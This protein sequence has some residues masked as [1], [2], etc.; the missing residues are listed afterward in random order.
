MLV[1]FKRLPDT[2]L[3]LPRC[4]DQL[5]D[6]SPNQHTLLGLVGKNGLAVHHHVQYTPPGRAYLGR[7]IQLL[8]NFPLEA[9]GLQ[10]NVDSG[11]TALDFDV[12]GF[13]RSSDIRQRHVQTMACGDQM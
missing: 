13:L 4:L 5:H 8:P 3:R 7:E 12:H 9:P 2:R 10:K 6:L 11:E 1:D